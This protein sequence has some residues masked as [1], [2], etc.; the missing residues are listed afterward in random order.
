[1]RYDAGAVTAP[2]GWAAGSVLPLR[3]MTAE[4]GSWQSRERSST[5]TRG[6]DQGSE[7]DPPEVAPA[8]ASA[9]GHCRNSSS[10]PSYASRLPREGRGAATGGEDTDK[11]AVMEKWTG[12]LSKRSRWINNRFVF[13][14]QTLSSLSLPLSAKG[15]SLKPQP[16]ALSQ[17]RT[18]D[19]ARARGIEAESERASGRGDYSQSI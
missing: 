10:S 5:A 11:Q 9:S 8:D 2:T 12:R 19:R 18:P 14:V 7:E 17:A 16:F 4:A 6:R 13:V 15:L 1:M 3:C